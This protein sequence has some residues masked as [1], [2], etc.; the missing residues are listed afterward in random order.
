MKKL[1]LAFLVMGGSAQTGL[2]DWHHHSHSSG[3][4]P[5]AAFDAFVWTSFLIL[6]AS[7]AILLF[8]GPFMVI[9]LRRG[10]DFFW[11]VPFGNTGLYILSITLRPY[12]G[13]FWARFQ[14]PGL[15]NTLLEI[16]LLLI[17]SLLVAL[18]LVILQWIFRTV[19]RLT[20]KQEITQ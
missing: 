1:A 6:A 11:A 5:D 9:R 20:K 18:L 7:A 19:K 17:S 2:C 8:A 10:R 13:G 14:L 4:T 15:T 16:V 3:G 12:P